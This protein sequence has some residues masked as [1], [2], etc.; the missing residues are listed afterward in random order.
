MMRCESSEGREAQVGGYVPFEEKLEVYQ[1]QY[2]KNTM[3]S[4]PKTMAEY[5]WGGKLQLQAL[6]CVVPPMH[7]WAPVTNTSG[8]RHFT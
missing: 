7:C 6:S 2:S 1:N 8:H 3:Q 5:Q 4:K